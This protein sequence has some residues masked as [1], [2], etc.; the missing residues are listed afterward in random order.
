M[1]Q[2]LWSLLSTGARTSPDLCNNKRCVALTLPVLC[3]LCWAAC[4]WCPDLR[5]VRLHTS[6]IEERKRLRKEVG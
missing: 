5:A 6:D 3:S 4:R 1:L 2:L